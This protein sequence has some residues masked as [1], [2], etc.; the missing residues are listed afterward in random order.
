MA[1]SRNTETGLKLEVNDKILDNCT[2][3]M[4]AIKVLIIKS[5]ELQKEIVAQGRV[6]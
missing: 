6:S 2:N 4:K 5:K 3:L 1:K